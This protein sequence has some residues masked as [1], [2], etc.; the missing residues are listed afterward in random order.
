[1]KLIFSAFT[2]VVLPTALYAQDQTDS[3][4]TN[5]SATAA[6]YCYFISGEELHPT[7]IATA[8]HKSLHLEARY[9]YE[10]VN[11]VSVFAGYTWE[12]SSSKFDLNITPMAGISAGNTNGVLPGL[13]IDASFS[14]LNFYSEN[15]YM[16]DFTGKENNFFYSWTQLS[17]PVLKNTQVGLISESLRWYKTKF[18]LQ[19]G[20]YIE[21]AKRNITLDL[22]Y[23]N[24]LSSYDFMVAAVTYEF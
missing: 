2:L 8:D 23:Y 11:T 21:Y 9:N 17:T 18:D 12:K 13:E 20:V 15:E 1:M 7:I 10:D 24:P 14:K 4:E 19:K 5:W 3:T 6:A 22:Y 16:L